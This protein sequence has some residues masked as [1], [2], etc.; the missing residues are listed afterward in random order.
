MRHRKPTR[1]ATIPMGNC[2]FHCRDFAVQVTNH[3]PWTLRCNGALISADDVGRLSPPG[4]FDRREYVQV[5][6][7]QPDFASG[8]LLVSLSLVPRTLLAQ[9][10]IQAQAPAA[11]SSPAPSS[12]P[13]QLQPR[14]SAIPW[15][16]TSAIRRRLRSTPKRR[17]CRRRYGIRWASPTR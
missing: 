10:A 14:K 9:T 15:L 2:R 1:I 7:N 4:S 5:H 12:P 11:A 8:T 3:V 16:P 6:E 17:R 13:Q